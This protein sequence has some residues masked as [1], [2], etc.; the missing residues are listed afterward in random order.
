MVTGKAPDPDVPC[1]FGESNKERQ[2][3]NM[4]NDLKAFVMRGNVLD[5]AA[6]VV[7]SGA[8][9]AIATSLVKDVVIL[10]IGLLLG[11]AAFFLVV[12][13]AAKRPPRGPQPRTVAAA[14]T[15]FPL[16]ATRCGYCTSPL[17][18]S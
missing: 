10:P 18:V 8:F 5:L 9:G 2:D 7:I 4:L 13:A 12:R 17:A 15:S 3:T 1:P 11:N 16:S 6:A 14:V